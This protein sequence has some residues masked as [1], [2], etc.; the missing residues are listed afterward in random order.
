MQT[1]NIANKRYFQII[2][3]AGLIACSFGVLPRHPGASTTGSSTTVRSIVLADG[4]GPIPTNPNGGGGKF[5]PE[6]KLTAD[7][8]GP[9]PTNPNGGGNK[10]NALPTIVADGGGPIPTN[11]GGGGNKLSANPMA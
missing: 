9:I 10:V 1:R 2:M 8:G 7:G 4:G 3:T 11:P 5:S 6:P